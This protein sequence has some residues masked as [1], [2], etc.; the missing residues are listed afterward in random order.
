MHGSWFPFKRELVNNENFKQM[1]PAQRLYF[2]LLV[3][4]YNLRGS[5]YKSDQEIA[6]TIHASVDTVR[7]A[8]KKL[9][10]LGWIETKPGFRDS[11]GREVATTYFY[12]KFARMKKGSKNGKF[13]APIHRYAFN[14]MLYK[15]RTGRLSQKEVLLFCYICYF[16]SRY[17][18]DKGEFFISKRELVGLTEISGAPE[19]VLSLNK[20]TIF[21]E[22]E[23]LLEL[24]DHYHKIK[25]LE[26]RG[27]ADPEQNEHN[28]YMAELFRQDIKQRV[29]NAKREQ[30]LKKGEPQKEQLLPLFK[31]LYKQTHGK[32]LGTGHDQEKELLSLAEKH[33]AAAVA[34]G[35]HA[36]FQVD[37]VPNTTGAK[38][39][40]L[41]NFLA[42]NREFIAC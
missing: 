20:V 29:E 3:S 4:E 17:S 35:I 11:S 32:P 8:R 7:R 16:E 27:F 36:Y 42:C 9:E 22:D 24:E 30:A 5:F 21:G 28:R 25:V 41:A 18:M 14:S 23:T 37:I 38:T 31:N 34:E 10:Q 12:V 1:S 26:H 39:R 15:L 19:A 2:L 13:F 40:T 6:V 33:G